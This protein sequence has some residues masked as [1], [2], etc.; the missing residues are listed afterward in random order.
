MDFS[1]LKVIFGSPILLL[2]TSICVDLSLSLSLS[3][4][5]CFLVD[6]KGCL[7]F[8]LLIFLFSF[9]LIKTEN[10]SLISPL[11]P[12]NLVYIL[13]YFFFWVY[14]GWL[15]SPSFEHSWFLGIHL[16]PFWSL[17]VIFILGWVGVRE[18]ARILNWK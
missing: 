15:L 17:Y 2:A 11:S 10:H 13:Y 8:S 3:L 5:F 6:G 16:C 18:C 9:N 14:Q 1:M 7:W 12:V 4:Y